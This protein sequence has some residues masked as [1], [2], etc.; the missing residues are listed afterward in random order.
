[1]DKRGLCPGAK[2]LQILQFPHERI[3]TPDLYLHIEAAH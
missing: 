1:M 2:A 3:N